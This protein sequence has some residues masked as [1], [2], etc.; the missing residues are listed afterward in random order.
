MAN[1][2][3][4]LATVAMAGSTPVRVLYTL[5]I[6]IFLTVLATLPFVPANSGAAVAAVLSLAVTLLTFVGILYVQRSERLRF[7]SFLKR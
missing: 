3:P 7:P 2:R 6:V 5:N 1:P 4:R